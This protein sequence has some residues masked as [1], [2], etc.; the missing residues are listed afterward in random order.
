[1]RA[2][3]QRVNQA[4]VTVNGSVVAE[5]SKGILIL[6]GFQPTDDDKAMNYILNKSVNLR[7]FEDQNDKMNLSVLDIH[8]DFLI[9]PNF[10]LYGDARKGNR[11]SYSSG[12]ASAIARAQFDRFIEIATQFKLNLKTGI[13]QADMKVELLNDGPV[14]LLLDSDKNF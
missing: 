7:I 12:S 2:V 11:P 4:K 1:M 5:I 8:G 6:V 3:L 13:F 10:T 14:T 9:V